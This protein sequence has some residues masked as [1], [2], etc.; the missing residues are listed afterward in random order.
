MTI[1]KSVNQ[2]QLI[3]LIHAQQSKEASKKQQ[4]WFN[5]IPQETE[6]KLNQVVCNQRFHENLIVQ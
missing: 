1:N 4:M 6:P 2:L 3:D 5:Y